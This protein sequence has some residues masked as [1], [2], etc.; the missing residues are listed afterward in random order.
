MKKVPKTVQPA[1]ALESGGTEEDAT[2]MLID[3]SLYEALSELEDLTARQHAK[4]AQLERA[5]SELAEQLGEIR[6][7]LSELISEIYD[8]LI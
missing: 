2:P 3:R 8:D 7:G 1:H 4:A 5:A 6:N